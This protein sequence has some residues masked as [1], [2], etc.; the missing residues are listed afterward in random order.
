M[1]NKQIF[2]NKIKFNDI[3]KHS[4][5]A[6]DLI[7]N[8]RLKFREKSKKE[9]LR[10]YEFEKWKDI[11]ERTKKL[12]TPILKKV[13]SLHQ[14]PNEL[15]SYFYNNDDIYSNIITILMFW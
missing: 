12:K 14:N 6:L 2:D 9:V 10:E 13:E 1:I 3:T 7:S 4:N 8:N 15:S 5:L 11:Y